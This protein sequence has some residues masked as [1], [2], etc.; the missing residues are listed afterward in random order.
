[1]PERPIQ[2]TDEQ[3]AALDAIRGFMRDETLDA[4]ILRGSA[5]TGKTTVIADVVAAVHQ[6]RL[7]CA[8]L[9]PTGRAA[10]ILGSK[11]GRALGDAVKTESKTIHSDIYTMTR[12]DVF[13]EAEDANDP[14]LRIIY[15]LKEDEP[16]ASLL[17]VDESSMVG[18]RTNK[19][20]LVQF[21]SGRL[22]SD[23][24]TYARAARAGRPRDRVTKL[25][26]VGDPAQLPPVG[27]TESPALCDDYLRKEFGLKVASYDL[28]VVMRQAEGSAILARATELRDAISAANFNSFSLK[29]DNKEIEKIDAARAVD[30][31]FEGLTGAGSSVAVTYSNAMALDYNNNVRERRWGDPQLP[32][33]VGDILL[34]NRNSR[35]EL[36]NGDLVRVMEVA[37]EAEVVTIMIKGGH[38]AALRFRQLT[39]AFREASGA[40]TR[41]Q[42]LVL[43]NLL[44]SPQ[45]ELTPIEQRA[46]LVHL[47]Q[48]YPEWRPKSAGFRQLLMADRYFNALQVKY[49]YAMTCHK[50]QG[51]EWDRVIVDF[52][53]LNGKRNAS[54][55]QWAYTAITR[56]TTKLAAVDPPKFT[57]FDIAWAGLPA[58]ASPQSATEDPSS[59]PDWHRFSFSPAIA[60][61]M[62]VHRRLRDLWAAKGIKISMLQHL[63]YCERYTLVRDD[64]QATIQYHYNGRRQ[65]GKAARGPGPLADPQLLDDSLAVFSVL[66]DEVPTPRVEPFIQEFLD[67]LDAALAR[68]TIRRTSVQ[69]MPHRLRVGFADLSRKGA[70][71]FAYTGNSAWTSA[72]EVGGPGRSGGLYEEVQRLMVPE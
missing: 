57:A 43:E 3:A 19:G 50:A 27:E 53:G 16:A 37:P 38:R 71:D 52:N 59:D 6:M 1:M 61:L 26:F 40:V 69:S 24:V 2:L 41:I 60:A 13:E 64:R 65:I 49:G 34:V 48:R 7:S 31:I 70:I 44:N 25:L 51:G 45:R 30:M 23:L 47:R 63:A 22:L 66:A 4:F 15:P 14:G 18:D 8:L 42:P 35:G 12:V 33:Q 72:Q 11:V 9:A 55:F 28:T 5:G 68:T 20:D 29:P 32:I 39:V 58:V 56:A 62:P 46:L 54:F 10:R 36:R 67:R 21:G 17:I